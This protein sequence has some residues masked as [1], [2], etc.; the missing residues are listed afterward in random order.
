VKS[1]D[2]ENN[3]LTTM[4]Y[5]PLLSKSSM[6]YVHMQALANLMKLMVSISE[7]IWI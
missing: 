7:I 3:T 6:A 1:I 4:V 5:Y 2:Y